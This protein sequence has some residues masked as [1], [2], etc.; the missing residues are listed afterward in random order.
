M[1][2]L[3]IP[4]FVALTLGWLL[5]RAV[6]RREGQPV[7][8]VLLAVCAGQSLLTVLSLHYD[9]SWAHLVR[10]VTA[11]LIPALAWMAFVTTALRR[12]RASDFVHLIGPAFVLF[13]RVT[14]PAA[15]DAVIP[16]LY[17]G[18]GAAILWTLVTRADDLPRLALGAGAQPGLI[19]RMIG[20]A[21][22][23]SA[24]SDAVIVAAQMAGRGGLVPM[25]VA[26]ASSLTLLL[27]GALTLAPDLTPDP[28]PEPL[29]DDP[30][31]EVVEAQAALLDRL[32]V[33]LAREKL[34]L[35]PD[36]T[37]NRLAR[38]L[39]VPA[40]R[41]SEAI[42]RQTGANVARLINESRI[43]AACDVLA[44]GQ[45]V[46]EAMLASGFNTKSNFNRAF[47]IA[48]GKSPTDWC[49]DR[50]LHQGNAGATFT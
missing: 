23:G 39:H 38:R 6:L 21:L 27:V 25:I 19:W 5:L 33:L 13:C 32:N 1:P 15:L 43:R 29:P 30:D 8:L 20:W 26:I 4:V 36:L 24:L 14:V 37:L 41:L 28:A 16:A 9:F 12:V 35:D 22:I 42:N 48:I 11:S 17:L 7:F 49:R 18:Y 50:P 3:P 44:A 40:K 45:S 47:L 34:Y 2:S 31:P 10:P 46:T